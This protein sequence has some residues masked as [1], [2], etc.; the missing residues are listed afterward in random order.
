MSIE[1][2]G[3]VTYAETQAIAAQLRELSARAAEHGQQLFH[4]VLCT[5]SESLNDNLETVLEM[6][7]DADE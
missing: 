6:E 4:F 5:A 1:S 7:A 3:P 2:T